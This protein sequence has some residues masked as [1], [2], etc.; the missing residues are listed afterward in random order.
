MRVS[1]LPDRLPGRIAVAAVA[2]LGAA[3]LAAW[4]L[5]F[6]S[7]TAATPPLSWEQLRN[8]TYP[9]ELPRTKQAPLKDG[10]YEEEIAPGSATRLTIRLADIVGFGRIDSGDSVDAAAVLIGSPGG[11]G[12]FIYLVVV[13]NDNGTPAP[14]AAVLLGDRVAVR[15]IRVEDHRMI[16]GM[17]VRAANDP[18][19]LLTKEVTRTYS[20][21]DGRLVQEREVATDLQSPPPDKFAYTPQPLAVDLG[22][23]VRREGILRPGEMVTFLVHGEAG[24][25]LN[26]AVRSQF[27]NAILSIQGVQDSVQLVS[28]TSFAS[29]W[30]GRLATTQ[31]YALTVVT[32]AGNDLKYDLSVELRVPKTPVPAATVTPTSVPRPRP[33]ATSTPGG[34]SS[35]PIVPAPL[36]GPFRPTPR[37]LSELSPGAAQFLDGRSPPWSAAVV[38]PSGATLYAQEGDVQLELASTVKILIA[39]AVLDAAQR[40]GRYADRFELSLLW[41]MIT[42]SD[43]DSATKLWDQ[44]GGGGGLR[45]YLA[46]VDAQGIRPYIGPFWGT[47]TASANGLATILARAV[48]GDLL[49]KE[50]RALFLSLIENVVPAQRWGISAGA[51]GEGTHGDLVGIKNGWYLDDPGWRV[52]SV[53][54]VVSRDGRLSYAI[55]VLTNRQPTWPYGIAT[56]EGVAE[57]VRASFR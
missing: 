28:R 4:L 13:L 53:G 52:N 12:T 14:A 46:A 19:A 47:S 36:T 44:I 39:L 51:E 18:L 43:N 15:A 49:N 45:N 1:R 10:A 23:T 31:D 56:I 17:R 32:L 55:A 35:A 6:R 16:V 33:T 57:Q 20:L 7:E 2:V 25:E 50:H 21:Q 9:S 22:K 24:Q 38:Q 8:A 27:N 29:T 54:F 48:F 41:P 11:T 40:E 30:T 42:I 26:V 5:V 3:G 34:S 37:P